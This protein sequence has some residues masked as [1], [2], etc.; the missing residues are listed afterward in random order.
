[1][2]LRN[3]AARQYQ[4]I[5]NRAASAGTASSTASEGWIA[6]AR[7]ALGMSAAGLARRLGVTRS[8]VSQAERAELSG[9]VTIKYMQQAA[10]AMG[11]RFV[12]M[13]VPVEGR[14][15]SVIQ[16]QARKKAQALVAR[17]GDH[18]SMEAQALSD[19][20]LREEV[21]RLATELAF[22]MPADLWNDT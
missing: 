5:V 20:Q 15:E 11:C 18:M 16:A 1:M 7:K 22:A 2:S 3:V 21:D 14:I 19:E 8:S 6:T 9:G 10:E 4:A 13:I 17:A 12:Y